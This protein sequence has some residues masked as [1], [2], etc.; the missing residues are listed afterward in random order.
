MITKADLLKAQTY[1]E[2]HSQND[3][4]VLSDV[5]GLFFYGVLRQVSCATFDV[6]S[7][8]FERLLEVESLREGYING[9]RCAHLGL[10]IMVL[11]GTHDDIVNI[12]GQN[13]Y[14]LSSTR[15]RSEKL[16]QQ[17]GSIALMHARH[18]RELTQLQSQYAH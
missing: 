17:E 4:I 8:L 13:V 11:E 3:C 10:N 16:S 18:V 15:A 1:L 9:I 2:R 7:A 14:S 5:S 6:S 12:E